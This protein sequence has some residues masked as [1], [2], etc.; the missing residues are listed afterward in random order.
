VSLLEDI[1]R[2]YESEKYPPE[3]PDL[4]EVF[5][6]VTRK[7]HNQGTETELVS[8][9]DHGDLRWGT[10]FVNV[11]RRGDE[12]VAVSDVRPATEYQN[13]GDYGDPEIYPVEKHTEVVT[14]YKKV[15]E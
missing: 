9:E 14:T 6:E 5:D 7:F 15:S 1:K 2:H 13:W 3:G 4:D 10:S 8:E 11:Y 12:L